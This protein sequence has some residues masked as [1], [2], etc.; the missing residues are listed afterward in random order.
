MGELQEREEGRLEGEVR[1]R[2][3]VDPRL[4]YSASELGRC[5]A[6]ILYDCGYAVRSTGWRRIRILRSFWLTYSMQRD[7]S[8]FCLGRLL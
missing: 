1:G 4:Q 3:A 7:I 5:T 8:I 6:V 2:E